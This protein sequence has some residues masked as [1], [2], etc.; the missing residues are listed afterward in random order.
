MPGSSFRSRNA[1]CAWPPPP[2]SASPLVASI[3]EVLLFFSG[4]LAAEDLVAMREASEAAHD[5]AM[6]L[7]VRKIVR[8]DAARQRHRTFL[9]GQVLGMRERQQEEFAQLAR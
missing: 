7:G 4:A 5:V 9:V 2:E 8:A 3:V 1:R 6:M